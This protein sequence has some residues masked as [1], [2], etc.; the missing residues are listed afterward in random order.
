M[1]PDEIRAVIRTVPDFPAKGIQFR[2]IGPLL[3][4]ADALRASV[5]LLAERAR[6]ATAIAG[7][8]ARGFIFGTAVA[9]RLGMA[10]VG[11]TERYYDTTTRLFVLE[12]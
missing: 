2:D 12:R 11:T 6:G 9:L 8:E 4:H 7:M 10:D 1:T 3:A 5:D